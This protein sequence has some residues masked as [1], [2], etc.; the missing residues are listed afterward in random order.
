MPAYE[1]HA[2]FLIT[3]LSHSASHYEIDHGRY[4][5]GD[6][7][8]S[9]GLVACL[10]KPG[11]KKLPYMDLP[12]E[13][14]DAGGNL[15]SPLREGSVIHYRCPGVH[16]PKSFDLWCEDRAGRADGVNNWEK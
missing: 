7:R 8:G 4:P 12:P 1:A 5:S 14:V 6:G 3:N 11:P 2:R 15:L 9:S 10:R 16:N 13:M